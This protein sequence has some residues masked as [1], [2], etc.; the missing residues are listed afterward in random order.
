MAYSYSAGEIVQRKINY[1]SI[2][3]AIFMLI[4]A[5]GLTMQAASAEKRWEIFYDDG[6]AE[7]YYFWGVR[8][9]MTCGPVEEPGRMLAVQFE[10]PGQHVKIV[11]VKYYVREA[12]RFKVRLF[13]SER[14]PLPIDL[15]VL[16][17]IHISEPTRP[18]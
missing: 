6:T 7:E 18:Y 4:L 2:F 5:T 13:D 9:L 11:S 3:F 16:S 15:E 12:E 17:L 8:R 14:E 1:I 10:V